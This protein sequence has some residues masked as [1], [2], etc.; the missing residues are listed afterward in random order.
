MTQQLFAVPGPV[1]RDVAD[2]HAT[3]AVLAGPHPADRWSV[4]VPLEDPAFPPARRR[5]AV[6]LDP[7][8]RRSDRGPG[9]RG[10]AEALDRAGWQIQQAE[11]PDVGA[12]AQVWMRPV[13][14]E[15]AATRAVLEQL[16]GP[17]ARA[18]LRD[19]LAF[20]PPWT[21]TGWSPSSP[22]AP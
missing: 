18:F 13:G 12:A 16:A 6:T 7:Q 21:A 9:V 4:P 20:S 15:I 19:V 14:T 11:P 2:P 8:R 1:G 17:D 3:L 10:A 5:V 22:A